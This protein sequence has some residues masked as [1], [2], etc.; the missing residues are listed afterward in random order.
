MLALNKNRTRDA[1]VAHRAYLCGDMKKSVWGLFFAPKSFLVYLSLIYI[2]LRAQGE[3]SVLLTREPPFYI[4][5]SKR[6]SDHEIKMKREGAFIT[7]LPRFGYDPIRGW[8]VGAE[9]YVYLN[10]RRGDPF[11]A[12]TPYRLRIAPS[13]FIYQNGRFSYALNIDIPYL[14]DK[15]WRLRA[16]VDNF[17]DPNAQY[18]GIGY[19]TYGPLRARDKRTG[20]VRTFQVDEYEENLALAELGSDGRYYTDEYYHQMVHDEQL[21][22]IALERVFLG[23]RLR[24]FIGYEALFTRFRSYKGQTFKVTTASGESVEAEQRTTL[25]DLQQQ[26]GTWARFRLA[27]YRPDG[28]YSFSSILAWAVMYDTRDFEPDPS[29]GVF[30]E[31]SHEFQT[32]RLGSEFEMNKVMLQAVHFQPLANWR[33]GTGRLVLAQLMA[34]GYIWG[35]RI[36]FIEL[37]DLSSQA[38]AGGILVLG[39][40]RSIRGYREARFV[41]PGV[42]LVNTE[43]R[44]RFYEFRLL[45]QDWGLGAVAFYDSG[46]VWEVLRE[47][48][49]T[50]WRGAPGAG[51][52]LSWNQS[53]IL[54][55]DIARSR[56]GLQTFFAFQHI[57]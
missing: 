11:F 56:E 23:G 50:D 9:G 33:G 2:G 31:Y 42:V 48:G 53:T 52:R 57:F 19:A 45:R 37:Y 17:I 3:D 49:T 54:R 27:G 5:P 6:L 43:L 46:R 16:D 24:T 10:G 8:G 29:R 32:K 13:F 35:P 12:Y 21:Y 41:A 38:E 55:W 20:Q 51:L 40:A 18:W 1:R 39:G 7:G 36:N 47:M 28:R 15:R 30:L 22:N 34:W 4:H 26:D 25:F 14:F 44:A